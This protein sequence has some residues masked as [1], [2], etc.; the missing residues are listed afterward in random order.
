M[1][2]HLPSRLFVTRTLPTRRGRSNQLWAVIVR[3]RVI[4]TPGYCSL[5][6]WPRPAP[7]AP[8]TALSRV[9]SATTWSGS[10]DLA[11]FQLIPPRGEWSGQGEWMR[12]ARLI[13]RPGRVLGGPSVRAAFGGIEGQSLH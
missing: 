2:G 6:A 8:R 13:D 3:A 1:H 12:F 7:P 10:R 5:D 4:V 11:A 9:K